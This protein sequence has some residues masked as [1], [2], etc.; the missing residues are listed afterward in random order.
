[1]NDARI[2]KELVAVAKSLTAAGKAIG[3]FVDDGFKLDRRGFQKELLRELAKKLRMRRESNNAISLK[4]SNGAILKIALEKM[5]DPL[6]DSPNPHNSIHMYFMVSGV[7][8]NVIP[9]DIPIGYSSRLTKNISDV[10]EGVAEE[11][12]NEYFVK[13]L[14]KFE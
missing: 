12:E 8:Q 2:A 5:D 9:F 10:A 1:M 4:L 11:F 14:R 3:D 7:G 13:L 6:W